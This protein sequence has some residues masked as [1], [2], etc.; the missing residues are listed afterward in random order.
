LKLGNSTILTPRRVP[1]TW[2]AAVNR[3]CHQVY[4]GQ[5]HTPSTRHPLGRFNR[6]LAARPPFSRS[7]SSSSDGWKA[8]VLGQSWPPVVHPKT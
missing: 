3:L 6:H 4:L 1:L 7:S 8:L 5:L 2:S